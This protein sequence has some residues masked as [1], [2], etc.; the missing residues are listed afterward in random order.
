MANLFRQVKPHALPPDAGI[1]EKDGKPHVRIRD[2]KRTR[3]FPLTKDGTRY[4]RP[5]EVDSL[6][7]DASK[8]RRELG[9]KPRVSFDALVRE[10]AREDLAIAERDALVKQAGYSAPPRASD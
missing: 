4:L 3:L 6:L 2:G 10:M 9:W 8:A 1:V 7:G 5:T